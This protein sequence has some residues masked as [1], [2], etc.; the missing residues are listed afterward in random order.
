MYCGITVN[1]LSGKGESI[2]KTLALHTWICPVKR[3]L[4]GQ[5]QQPAFQIQRVDI[6]EGINYELGI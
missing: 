1:S 3:R 5:Q 4:I 2:Y 6:A